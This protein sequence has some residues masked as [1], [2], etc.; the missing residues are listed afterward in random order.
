M[1]TEPVD[2]TTTAYKLGYAEAGSAKW[3]YIRD[4]W[5]GLGLFLIVFLLIFGQQILDHETAQSKIAS[6]AH[7]VD[8]TGCIKAVK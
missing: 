5:G 3:R 6:C 4:M 1:D 7:A 8:V 2:R